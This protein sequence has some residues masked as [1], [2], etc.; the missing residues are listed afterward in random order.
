MIPYR[1]ENTQ[2]AKPKPTKRSKLQVYNYTIITELRQPRKNGTQ[3]SNYRRNDGIPKQIQIE[4]IWCVCTHHIIKYITADISRATECRDTMLT[5]YQQYH[6]DPNANYNNVASPPSWRHKYSMC[7]NYR[8]VH[9]ILVS[10]KI[11]F[12]RIRP[13]SHRQRY[14]LPERHIGLWTSL[15]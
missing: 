5:R 6:A 10:C 8:F 2:Y 14:Q 3:Y 15:G 4:C 9:R 1:F 7:S 11:C 13:Q 12:F